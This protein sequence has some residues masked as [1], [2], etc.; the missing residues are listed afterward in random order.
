MLQELRVQNLALIDALHLDLSS[1][2]TGLIVLTGETGAGK[3]IILQA[4]NLLTGGRGATSWVRNDSDQAGIEAT[5]SLRPEHNEINALLHEH[6]LRDGNN[7]IIRRI[8]AREGRSKLYVNDQSVTTRLCGELTANLINIASQHDHQ[9]LLN[10]RNHLHFLDLFGELRG[11][12]QQFGK[13]FQRWQHASS[14]LRELLDK[15]QDKEQQRDFLRFQLEEIR[16]CRPIA[17]EDEALMREREQL[18]ASDVLVRLVGESTERMSGTITYAL[19]EIRKNIEHAATID[20]TLAPLAER[21]ASAGYELED[22]AASLVQYQE[23]IPMDPSRLEWISGRLAELKQLQRK[24]G[25]TLEEVIAF[26]DKAEADLLVLESLEEEIAQAELRLEEIST[27]ALLRATELSQARR[28]VARKL[29][30]GMAQELA[31]LS[32]NQAVFEVS[33]TVPEGLGLDG[34]QSTGRDIV[35][36]LFSANPGEPPKPLAKIVSGGE[37]SRLMLAMKCLLA[38]RDQV[39]TVIFDEV[40]AGIGGQAAEAVAAK[41]GELAGHH[42]VLCIT[43]LPQIAAWADLHFKVEKQV[44]N[45]RTRTVIIEL[46]EQERIRELARML[47]GANP[48]EQTLAFA[49]ELMTRNRGRKSACVV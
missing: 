10:N 29:E 47:G 21:I 24:Y 40:D 36:F 3:S 41:I 42:Q 39:D 12:R 38:R 17:G 45:Q 13:L 19:V 37:L 34:I 46:D 35:E 7:C 5:F 8:L 28:E 15:E 32:F 11:M 22:L 20:A 18:K 43:H 44:E 25:P 31:S 14:E 30:A 49:R 1:W 2:K 6:S 48:S 26:A 4:I 33:L 9:Q 23:S 16:K 27:E